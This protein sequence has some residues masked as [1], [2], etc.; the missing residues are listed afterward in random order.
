MEEAA[1]EVV[2]V[3]ISTMVAM[4]SKC[5]PSSNPKG[6]ISPVHCGQRWSECFESLRI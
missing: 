1:L 2:V 6:D 5:Q 4:H 3:R